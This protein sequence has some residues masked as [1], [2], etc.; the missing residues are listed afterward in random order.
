M[1]GYIKTNKMELK[2]REIIAYKGY[3]CGICMTLKREYGNLSRLSLN[4]DTTFLQILL[5]SLYEPQ[6]YGEKLRCISH[7]HKK[8]VVIT[9]EI[10]KYCSAMNIILTYYKLKD[11]VEDDNSLKAKALLTLIKPAFEKASLE[12][13]EKTKV[14]GD[15]LKQLWDLEKEKCDDVEAL[16]EIFGDIMGEVFSYKEDVFRKNLYQTGFYL[17]KYIYILDAFDDLEEDIKNEKYNPFKNQNLDKEYIKNQLF[18]LLSCVNEELDRLP[19]IRNKGIIDNI[20]FSGIVQRLNKAM[21]ETFDEEEI[22][23]WK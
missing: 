16:A 6:D 5:T 15:L 11:D 23:K 20:L 3:Y 19:L 17:G 13:E 9:N 21:K 18:F 7:P 1:F 4:Y 10:S 8:E 12:Y 14:I 22:I 2:Y